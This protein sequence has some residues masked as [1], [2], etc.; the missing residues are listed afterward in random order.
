MPLKQAT[1]ANEPEIELPVV[2]ETPSVSRRGGGRRK[3]EV[4]AVGTSQVKEHKFKGLLHLRND[5]KNNNN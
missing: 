5:K 2:E 3:K 4:A 1:G